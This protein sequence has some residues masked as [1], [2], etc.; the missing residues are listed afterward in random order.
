LTEYFQLGRLEFGENG[1]QVLSGARAKRPHIEVICFG[2]ITNLL[3][4]SLTRRDICW[5]RLVD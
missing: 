5:R 4:H 1:L 3:R 2:H